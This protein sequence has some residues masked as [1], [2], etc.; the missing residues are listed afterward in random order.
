MRCRRAQT[1]TSVL[2]WKLKTVGTCLGWHRLDGHGAWRALELRLA[3]HLV[4]LGHH[5]YRWWGKKKGGGEVLTPQNVSSRQEIS[6][7]SHTEARQSVAHPH[8][9]DLCALRGG[10]LMAIGSPQHSP[11]ASLWLNG[12]WTHTHTHTHTHTLTHQMFLSRSC[13]ARTKHSEEG[14]ASRIAP[15]CARTAPIWHNSVRQQPEKKQNRMKKI[16]E[17]SKTSIWRYQLMMLRS[18]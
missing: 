16:D 14:W 18:K 4:V 10:R 9:R 12:I 13:H 11:V 2:T 15:W 8:Q 6:G 3:L 5:W 7:F 1:E 17:I